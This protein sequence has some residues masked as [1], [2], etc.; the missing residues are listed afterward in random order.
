MKVNQGNSKV[1]GESNESPD[2]LPDIQENRPQLNLERKSYRQKQMMATL[3]DK[4]QL[5]HQTI[6]YSEDMNTRLVQ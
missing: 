4:K 3:P 5:R 2:L 1:E 6:M